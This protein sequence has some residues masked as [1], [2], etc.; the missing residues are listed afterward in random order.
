MATNKFQALNKMQK[1]LRVYTSQLGSVSKAWEL[2]V[3][4]TRDGITRTRG[5]SFIQ[6]IGNKYHVTLTGQTFNSFMGAL[7][8]LVNLWLESL[9]NLIF[10][11]FGQYDGKSINRTD[12]AV[13]NFLAPV[14]QVEK[15]RLPTYDR[16]PKKEV[17]HPL[18]RLVTK[19][20][21]G[22]YSR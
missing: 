20:F 8:S 16:G 19:V 5:V 4:F 9:R 7:G 10:S 1:S 13:K 12:E 15:P 22:V 11:M 3:S 18:R 2:S 6:R 14:P 21:G 17:L